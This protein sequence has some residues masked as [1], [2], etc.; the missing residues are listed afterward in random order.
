VGI[1]AIESE[2]EMILMASIGMR[3]AMRKASIV[4]P[5]P[6]GAQPEVLSLPSQ[7][8]NGSQHDDRGGRAKNLAIR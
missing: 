3:T 5:V 2:F 6:I 8:G 4:A 7:L 1:S